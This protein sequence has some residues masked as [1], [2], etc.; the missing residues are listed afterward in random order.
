ML[1]RVSDCLSDEAIVAHLSGALTQ[2]ARA[3]VEGHI[4]R[5]DACRG[6][7]ADAAFGALANTAASAADPT[8]ATGAAID[9][10]GAAGASVCPRPGDVIADKYLV[11]D[12]LGSG[13]MGWVVAA[14]HRDL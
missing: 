7:M 9:G 8:P 11:E 4:V 12:Y 13:S 1:A 14:R 3:A 10:P 6:L 2:D 5:C